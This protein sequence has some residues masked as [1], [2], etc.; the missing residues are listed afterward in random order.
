[1]HL[2]LGQKV[3]GQGQAVINCAAGVVKLKFHG[4]IFRVGLGYILA[5]TSSRG[6]SYSIL[7]RH[8]RHARF[9]RD[10]LAT[11]SQGCHQDATRKSASV[12]L[13]LYIEHRCGGIQRR[14]RD[15]IEVTW[16]SFEVT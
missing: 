6:S 13:K 7:V 2:A 1:M 10:L 8:V 14:C 3:K 15:V 5:R 9:P 12:E 4:T 11:S 16:S